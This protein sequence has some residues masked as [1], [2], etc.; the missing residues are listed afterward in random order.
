M[1]KS[2]KILFVCLGNICRSPSAE[3]V[4][5]GFIEKKG[6][7]TLFEVDSAGTSD[8]HE[9]QPADERMQRHALKRNYQLT[10]ISRP[11]KPETDFDNF[12]M[13]VAMDQ[14]NLN[15]LRFMVRKRSD[16]KKL[17]LMT[18]YCSRFHHNQ[19][20]DPYYG[21]ADGFELV[22][23]ILEDASEGLYERIKKQNAQGK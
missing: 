14:Q 15:D 19:V 22:L 17:S 9:G 10:S 23:D 11:F 18:D 13:I 3:A 8:Y 2:T 5:K 1:R 4:F 6:E 12:D 20:P 21:G 16:L 7:S